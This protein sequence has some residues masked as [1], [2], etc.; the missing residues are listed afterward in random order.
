[1][2][3]SH[4]REQADYG[5]WVSKRLVYLPGAVG[6]AALAASLVD[7]FFLIPA[8]ALLAVAAYFGYARHLFAPDG[9]DVQTKVRETLLAKLEW[10]GQGR[11][12]DIGCG[13]APLR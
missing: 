10:D 6:V 8:A 1:M 11:A 4:E 3:A 12:I 5:N 13:T 9:G 2:G 7:I